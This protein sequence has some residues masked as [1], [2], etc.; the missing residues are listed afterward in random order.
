MLTFLKNLLKPVTSMSD[1][2]RGPH[3]PGAEI[4]T[5][6]EP[7][8]FHITHWK[9]G[10]QWIARILRILVADRVV[11]PF[12]AKHGHVFDRPICARGVYPAVYLTK[13]RFDQV[14]VPGPHR[15]F[16]II[17]DLRDTLVSL[18]FSVKVSHAMSADTLRYRESLCDR[19]AEAGLLYTLDTLLPAPAEIQASWLRAGEAILRYEDLLVND[20]AILERVLLDHCELRVTKA[21]L[22]EAILASRFETLTK[23]RQRGEEDITAHERK[24]IHGDWRNHFTDAVKRA[25]K[26]RFGDV[27]VATGYECDADW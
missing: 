2:L 15:R 14:V 3:R 23:G 6:A 8:V 21:K 7:T 26:E 11:I 20:V 10:S 9:A 17:R 27:L 19:D 1:K 16:V 24:G 13:E 22:H 25:F 12:D 18:Y 4:A 5:V